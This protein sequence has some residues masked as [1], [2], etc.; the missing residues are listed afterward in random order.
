MCH[1][2]LPTWKKEC[3][4]TEENPAADPG[5]QRDDTPGPCFPAGLSDQTCT[6]ARPLARL[7]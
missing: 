2:A 3:R 5:R 6:N 4:V 1:S 7:L